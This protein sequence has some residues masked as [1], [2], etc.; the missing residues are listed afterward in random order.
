MYMMYTTY[1]NG[2]TKDKEKSQPVDDTNSF[3]V[4]LGW[5]ELFFFGFS[6]LNFTREVDAIGFTPQPESLLFLFY[7]ISPFDGKPPH[8]VSILAFQLGL[9]FFVQNILRLFMCT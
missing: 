1:F 8:L 3:C 7:L 6:I 2:I 9:S 5:S 4:S